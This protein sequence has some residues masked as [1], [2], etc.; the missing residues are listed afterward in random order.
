MSLDAQLL[1]AFRAADDGH[2]TA[3]ELS[4]Q[5]GV[6]RTTISRHIEELRSL[7]YDIQHQPSLGYRLAASPDILL[8]EDIQHRLAKTVI[9]RQ[10]LV[11]EQTASTN[12]LV[13]KLALDGAA[14]GVVVFAESQTRGRGRMGRSWSSPRGKGL[15][16]SAL[17]RPKLPMS[18]VARLTIAA[19]V[20]I[21]CAIQQQTGLAAE[22]KWPN[23]VFIAGRKCAGILA[24]LRTEMDAIKFVILGI[25][26]DVNCDTS[27][28]PPEVR[29]IA[30]SLKM[31]LAKQEREPMLRGDLAVALLRELNRAYGLAGGDD[32]FDEIRREWGRLSSTLG[33]RVALQIGPHR[34]EGFA[35]ALDEDGSLL[36]RCDD[37]RI[38]HVV[39][40]DVMMEK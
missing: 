17:L 2:I 39:S 24:E 18:S 37:G 30:T 32:G 19:S 1:A 26:L 34:L 3:A 12:D 22:I 15:W 38:E 10:V 7:G 13:E 33:K 36:V 14:E 29:K 9:G 20:A 4:S 21:A 40:G 27:D 31:E 16:F 35:Q 28:F 23:D 8:A 5:L 25:G 11:Y 6:A